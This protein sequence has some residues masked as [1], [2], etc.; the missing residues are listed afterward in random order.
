MKIKLLY[1]VSV[2]TLFVANFEVKAMEVRASEENEPAV[3]P[4]PQGTLK[5]REA[6]GDFV[7]K[8]FRFNLGTDIAKTATLDKDGRVQVWEGTS[9]A[10]LETLRDDY[11]NE[12]VRSLDFSPDFTMLII[13]T[14]TGKV[15]QSLATTLT[16][17]EQL[18]E[19]YSRATKQSQEP[20][21]T[22]ESEGAGALQAKE[23]ILLRG[24][25]F[26]G[27]KTATLDKDGQIQIWDTKSGVLLKSLGAGY[28]QMHEKIRSLDFSFNGDTLIIEDPYGTTRVSAV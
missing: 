21:Y 18:R 20:R 17:A 26:G 10:L 16:E 11:K 14:P 27:R 8:G 28:N 25:D 2:A 12:G 24:T 5:E 15:K 22:S 4:A 6:T 19:I 7:L 9:G 1:I 3:I 23:G 13:E